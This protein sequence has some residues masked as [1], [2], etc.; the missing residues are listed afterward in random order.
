MIRQ[1]KLQQNSNK[2]N[3]QT[4]LYKYLCFFVFVYFQPTSILLSLLSH[5]SFTSIGH[6]I[7]T[8]IALIAALVKVTNTSSDVVICRGALCNR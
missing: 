1:K 2:G 4:I 7:L 8:D 3:M 6:T 5:V